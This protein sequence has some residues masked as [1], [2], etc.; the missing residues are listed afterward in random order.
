MGL[1]SM[2][3]TMFS[4]KKPQLEKVNPKNRIGEI[5]CYFRKVGVAVIKIS[6]GPLN[7]NERIWIKG[8]TTNNK[9]T[10]SSMEINH[11]SV[12]TAKKGQSVGLKIKQRARR[13]DQVYRLTD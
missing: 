8:H 11:K 1:L 5:E 9:F 4:G 7:Q 6:K 2:V 12:T 3:S 13:G 10:T